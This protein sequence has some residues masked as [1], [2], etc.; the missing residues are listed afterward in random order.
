MIFDGEGRKSVENRIQL[1]FVYFFPAV[2]VKVLVK[3]IAFGNI[4]SCAPRA[5][6]GT[7]RRTARKSASGHGSGCQRSRDSKSA[8]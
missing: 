7:T 5:G 6:W 8:D 4:V 1:R 3:V 2:G